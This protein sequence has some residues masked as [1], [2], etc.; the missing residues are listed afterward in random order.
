[1]PG[2]RPPPP[3]LGPRPVP[4]LPSTSS[5]RGSC[6]LHSR[7]SRDPPNPRGGRPPKPHND[8]AQPSPP[9]EDP[10]PNARLQAQVNPSCAPTLWDS[11]SPPPP[12]NT[13]NY[14][15]PNSHKR[16]IPPPN[17][18]HSA[19]LDTRRIEL[20][21]SPKDPMMNQPPAVSLPIIPISREIQ[22]LL[23]PEPPNSTGS[24]SRVGDPPQ[25]PRGGPVSSN[26]HAPSL[27]APLSPGRALPPSR[28]SSLA[29]SPIPAGPGLEGFSSPRSGLS[30]PI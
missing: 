28:P 19:P 3:P 26:P 7:R 5:P 27:A 2:G 13:H 11:R 24:Q 29:P 22:P 14:M 1:M 15:T 12:F 6:P 17:P 18:F 25:T 21:K 23:R 4:P 8:P 30:L 16:L 10:A 20:P 9:G